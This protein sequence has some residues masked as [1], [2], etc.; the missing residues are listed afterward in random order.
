MI[1]AVDLRGLTPGGDLF[2]AAPATVQDR[3]ATAELLPA[4]DDG[5]DVL[6]VEL[7]QPRLAPGLLARDQG[8]PSPRASA[9]SRSSSVASKPI[10]SR[11]KLSLCSKA[12]PS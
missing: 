1:Y 12:S 5:V 11:S 10:R 3:G 6:R 4:R 7:D 2:V 8:G 9:S